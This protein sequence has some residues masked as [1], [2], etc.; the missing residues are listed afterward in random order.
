MDI[1]TFV[2]SLK[3]FTKILMIGLAAEAL[4]I[5]FQFV[6]PQNLVMLFPTQYLHVC[7]LVMEIHHF[8]FLQ[9]QT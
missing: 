3:P 8:D 4:L 6:S 2:A 7:L 9:R 5:T 1:E